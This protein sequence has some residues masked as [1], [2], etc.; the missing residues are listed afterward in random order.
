MMRRCAPCSAL[1]L[2]A[3]PASAPRTW[4]PASARTLIQITSNYTGSDIVVFGAIEQPAGQRARRDIVVVVRGP[5]ADM[6]VRRRDRVAGVWINH[7]AAKLQGMPAY[8][9]LASTRPLSAIAPPDA[10]ARYGIGLAEPAARRRP[11]P[12]RSRALPPGGA[13]PS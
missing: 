9:Y 10:L 7:D 13:A 6:T 1:L 8:Y 4:S 12:S 11:Q 2:A 3:S 5:D